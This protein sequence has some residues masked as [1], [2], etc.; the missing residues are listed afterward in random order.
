MMAEIGMRVDTANGRVIIDFDE[1]V[2]H[3]EFTPQ[4]AGEFAKAIVER[5][6]KLAP[7]S[8]IVIPKLNG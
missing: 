4:Q 2:D 7:K 1:A 3:L 8:P 5:A 6:I